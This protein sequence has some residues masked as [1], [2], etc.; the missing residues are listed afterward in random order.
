MS[1]LIRSLAEYLRLKK[2]AERKFV[3][4]LG[5][6]A[7]F[8]SG[9]KTTDAITSELVTS[10]GIA[11]PGSTTDER[12]DELW[13]ASSRD[14]RLR[15]LQPY[16]DRAPS[17]GYERLAALIADGYFDVVITFNFDRLL[18]RALE[19]AGFRD[20]R[21]IVRGEVDR[22]AVKPLVEA[23]E[24]RVKI[25][26][27]HGSL[28]SADYFLFS[29]DEMLNY[30]E[31]LRDVLVDL[32][33]RDIIICG[34]A[35]NDQCVQR[36]F[37]DDEDA[38]S[39]Y[40][41]N[42]AGAGANIRP[43]LYRRRSK[44]RVI[45]GD[46][47][48]FDDFFMALHATLTTREAPETQPRRPR[49]NLFKFLDHYHEEDKPWFF[50]RRQLTR[51]LVER[52][53]STPPT[54]LLLNGKPK[55]GKSSF[56][57]AGLIPSLRPERFQCVYVRGKRDLE[58]Q[59]RAELEAIPG[60]GPSGADWGTILARLMEA[61]GKRLVLVLDQ[62]EKFARAWET[63]SNDSKAAQLRFL[64]TLVEQANAAK[65]TI[66]LSTVDENA[67][68]KLNFRL[69]AS[70]K[71]D[72]CDVDSLEIEVEPLPPT[73]VSSIVRHA[74]R[75]SGTSISP[76]VLKDIC[77]DRGLSTLT[78]VQT[79]C[80]YLAKGHYPNWDG[81]DRLNDQGL[82]AALDSIRDEGSIID[83]VDDLPC[84]ER[85]LIRAFLKLICEPSGSTRKI[86]D[87]IRVHFPDIKDDRF[88]EPLA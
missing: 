21:V 67:F 55:V 56:V 36:A 19:T 71:S 69:Q 54:L 44:D 53:E 14:D 39:V 76:A 62:F 51:T 80:Y 87:F 1:D 7:S 28:R 38:G 61:S 64:V 13:R 70:L 82:R 33:S 29:T 16:L 72:K 77:S 63:G 66:V 12:F 32:T 25:L 84:H 27:L 24:P 17:T 35:F 49:Q 47:G 18:E 23:K 68:W 31:E 41:V 57:R 81:Y 78:H 45:S 6:G 37:S 86:I 88:P 8:S 2:G 79:V 65:A 26:K 20:Y 11:R 58:A 10:Y 59:L 3:L 40:Y 60:S 73:L 83:L 5:A 4:M 52:F 75:T 46:A 22:N 34:Y 9:V 43:Y 48:R 30:P 42:P 85:R 74:A 15:M 50:G